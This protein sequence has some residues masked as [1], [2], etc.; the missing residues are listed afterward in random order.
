MNDYKT[1][2]SDNSFAIFLFHGV[3]RQQRHSVRNYTAKHLLLDR[4]A[5]V[6]G[7]LAAAGT[8][9]SVPEI[10]DA[11]MNGKR[12]PDRSFAITFDDGFENNFSVA[13][14][15]LAEL[16]IPATFYVTSDFI[17]SNGASWIDII[18][19][20]IEEKD[21]L[22]LSLPFAELSG[23]YAGRDQKLDLL[24]R[25]RQLVK[26]DSQIDPYEFAEEIKRQAGVGTID[27][28]QELDQK[29]SWD[30]VREL[31]GDPL[32][33]IGGHGQTHRILEYLEQQDLE[34]EIAVCVDKLE[35]N[36]GAQVRHFSYPEGLA[37][38]Y[39]QRVIDVMKNHGIVCAPTAEPGVN[40]IGDDLFRLKRMMVT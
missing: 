25:I 2:L 16:K 18:E 6:V 33:T 24:N 4:F 27:P 39:S 15:V 7:D 40:H 17:E 13:A 12:L 21:R 19:Y 14:P 30:Q 26:S 36:L 10:V 8:P 22:N 37:H 29:M 38:C 31:A 3:I 5:A 11:T 34:Q 9:V 20:V 28:D 35:S 23:S 32:F 1:F